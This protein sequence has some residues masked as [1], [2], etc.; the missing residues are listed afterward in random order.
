MQ[1]FILGMTLARLVLALRWLQV[2]QSDKLVNE[3]GLDL[4][5]KIAGTRG[6]L[7]KFSQS[8]STGLVFCHFRLTNFDELCVPQGSP[9]HSQHGPDQLIGGRGIKNHRNHRQRGCHCQNRKSS[10]TDGHDPHLSYDSEATSEVDQ[11]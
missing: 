10:P 11:R 8:Q 2:F 1:C 7:L 4:E 5:K 9:E 6:S 3:F